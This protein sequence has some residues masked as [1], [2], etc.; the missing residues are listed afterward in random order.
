MNENKKPDTKVA[1]GDAATSVPGDLDPQETREWLDSLDSVLAADGPQRA[2]Y[3][4][5]RLVERARRSGAYLPYRANTA[6]INT[7]PPGKEPRY[8]GDREI[9]R[10]IE[11]FL[12][13]NAVAMVVQA[14]RR[15]TEYGG[16]IAS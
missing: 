8:P 2:H 7:I 9:E 5:E 14:N 15:S 16:H 13:W 11:A 10:R 3:L 12:R 6:Y 4:I 1:E